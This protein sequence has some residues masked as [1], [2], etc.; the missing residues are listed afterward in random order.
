MSRKDDADDAD[1]LLEMLRLTMS[2]RDTLASGHPTRAL[3][4][5]R[6]KHG[7]VVKEWGEGSV[8]AATS[9]VDLG[10]ALLDCGHYDEARSLL[11]WSLSRYRI[12]RIDDERLVRAMN[13]AAMAAY[14]ASDYVAAE[15]EYRA[16]IAELQTRGSDYRVQRARALDHLAQVYGRQHR[17]DETEPLLLEA[18]AIFQAEGNLEDLAVCLSMLGSTYFGMH[19]FREAEAAHRRALEI[20]E[21]AKGSDSVQVAK[22]L[23]HLAMAL[24]M[25][26]Q[27]ERRKDL[28][29]EA[30][31]LGE[32]AVRLFREGLPANHPSVLFSRQNLQRYRSMS[33]SIGMMFQ[34]GRGEVEPATTFNSRRLIPRACPPS[35]KQRGSMPRRVITQRL[36]GCLMT[37][38]RRRFV[39]WVRRAPS[40][41]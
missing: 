6:R 30:V 8:F 15:S 22:T 39:S 3:S 28:A 33:A 4:T 18:L 35:S 29:G 20:E 31:T 1:V 13:A 2:G 17:Y 32:R 40:P 26:A 5:L 34:S 37:P 41:T 11:T 36:S 7:L 14:Q 21:E 9:G 19:R 24:A 10:E 25:R 38:K 16:M 27:S 23:D 12:L